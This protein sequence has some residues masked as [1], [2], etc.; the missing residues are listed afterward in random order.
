MRWFVLSSVLALFLVGSSPARAAD[1]GELK[2]GMLSGMFRDQQP[3]V[4]EALSKPFRDLMTKHIGYNGDVEVVDDP[5]AL[6]DRLK[7]NKVQ[8]G[9]FHGFEFAWAQQRCDDL[10]PLIVTQPTGGTVQGILVVHADCPAKSV[11]DL[12][13][14]VLIPRGAKA[15]TLVFFDKLRDGVAAD[16]AKPTTKTDQT[17]E[18]VLNAVA[19]GTAKAAL[20]DWCAL[21]GYKVLHPSAF[22]TLKVLAKSEEFPPAVVCYRKGSLTDDQATRIRDGMAASCKTPTGRMLMTLW[23]L[24]GFEAPPKGYQSSLDDILK[25]YPAPKAEM[26]TNAKPAVKP[27]TD[28]VKTPSLK[29]PDGR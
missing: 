26:K 27:D 1:P 15:H 14:E 17:P 10:I 19:N 23:N 22:K 5:M 2:I 12:K 29:E 25:A 8:L 28:K 16:V 3:K 21:D 7:E 11:A 9:V 18:D 24:K 13:V 6:C 4:I 20:V